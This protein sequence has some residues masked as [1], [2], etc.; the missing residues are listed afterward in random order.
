MPK[1]MNGSLIG[2]GVAVVTLLLS[3][4]PTL[5]Q[6][7]AAG[8]KVFAVCKACHQIG[9]TA[10]NAVGPALNGLFRGRKAGT[11]PDYKYS[12]AY[13]S[14]DKVWDK[15]NFVIYIKDPRGVTPGTKMTYPGQK[16][17]QKI[18]DLIAFLDQYETD[19]SKK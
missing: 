5:A 11:W 18:K 8:E 19:G 16:D 14:L 10:K 1:K 9:P 17:E 15:D 7:A 12:A 3:A 6:D 4:A 2:A 13:Q